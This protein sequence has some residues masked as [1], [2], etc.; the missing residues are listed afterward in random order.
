MF[1]IALN[2]GLF[3]TLASVALYFWK[4]EPKFGYAAAILLIGLP[5]I[6]LLLLF[7]APPDANTMR[8]FAR[9]FS[10]LFDVLCMACGAIMYR[11]AKQR[12]DRM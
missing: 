9:V 8:S 1:D 2:L 10:V 6:H 4:K 12:E 7:F 11:L 5:L 3:A